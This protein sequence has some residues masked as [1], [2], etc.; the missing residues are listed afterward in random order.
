MQWM[1]FD[2]MIHDMCRK[3][4]KTLQILNLTCLDS[5]NGGRHSG[6]R[7]VVLPGGFNVNFS[8]LLQGVTSI[9]VFQYFSI[10]VW[11]HYNLFLSVPVHLLRHHLQA[12]VEV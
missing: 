11:H 6:G 2:Q 1:K 5:Y 8:V 7:R 4:K 3:L 12:E 9:L 10:Q